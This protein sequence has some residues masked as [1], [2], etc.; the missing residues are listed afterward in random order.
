MLIQENGLLHWI[1]NFYG[2]GSWDAK[3]WFIGHEEGGGDMPEEVADKL[4]YFHG[5]FPNEGTSL[6]D[7]RQLYQNVKFTLRGPKAELFNNLYDYRFGRNCIVHGI[8]KNLIAFVHAHE[9]KPIPDFADYQRISFA[10]PSLKTE[11]LIKLYPLPAPHNHAWYYSWLQLPS[12]SFLKSRNLYEEQLYATRIHT[13]LECLNKHK[14]AIVLMY[15]MNNINRLKAS[16]VEKF[17]SAN[18][19]M[20]KAVARTIPQ[21]HV[22]NLDGTRL[23]ITTQIPGLRHNRIE[24][25]FDWED[26][27]RMANY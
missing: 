12:I 14:P 19:K 21:H 3:F 11:S 22:T 18:F 13:I 25:G 8:W 27:G 26:F 2:Y 4:R 20:I 17:P 24:T 6:C 5:T 16:V 1:E 10:D 15:G 7:I 23:I 9:N